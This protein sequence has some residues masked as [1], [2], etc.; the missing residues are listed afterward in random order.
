L[1]WIYAA[2]KQPP[3]PTVEI[4]TMDSEPTI[5]PQELDPRQQT[6]HQF[7]K[8]PRPQLSFRPSREALA[9]RANET[10]MVQEDIMRHQAFNQM[11]PSASSS[12]SASNSPG[13]NQ[14]STD[15]DMDMDMDT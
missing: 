12:T 2:Q 9:P 15:G 6:L 7:F 1:R 14:T 11:N 3:A 13:Y 5:E 4:E 10:A 8:A